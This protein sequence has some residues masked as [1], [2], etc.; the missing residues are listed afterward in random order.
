MLSHQ[1]P[2]LFFTLVTNIWCDAKALQKIQDKPENQNKGKPGH[3]I[4]TP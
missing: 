1:H 4:K 3:R 2:P